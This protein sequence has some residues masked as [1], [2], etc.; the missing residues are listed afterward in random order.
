MT[1][2]QEELVRMLELKAT[3]LDL[4][5][6]RARST[7]KISGEV[8]KLRSRLEYRRVFYTDGII[9]L[10]HTGEPPLRFRYPGRVEAAMEG[11]FADYC[12]EGMPGNSLI[13]IYRSPIVE[14][15]YLPLEEDRQ[16]G[17]TSPQAR[18]VGKLKMSAGWD[19]LEKSRGSYFPMHQNYIREIREKLVDAQLID[20]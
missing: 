15:Y 7:K 4:R 5:E 19:F 3:E 10:Q 18:L 17:D 16:K 9:D 11:E 13:A 20:Y 14:E 12:L 1:V 8:K 6:K 2:D